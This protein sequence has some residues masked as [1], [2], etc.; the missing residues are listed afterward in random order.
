[1]A[2]TNFKQWNPPASNQESDTA[3]ATDAQ[4]TGGAAINSPFASALANKLFYQLTTWL[5]AFANSLVGKGFSPN[6]GSGNPSTAIAT[7]QSILANILTTA[8]TISY[9]QLS[10]IPASKIVPFVPQVVAVYDV[11]ALIGAVPPVSTLYVPPANGI[12]RVSWAALV[13]L[14]GGVGSTL[15][16]LTIWYT[17]NV[18]DV[19][20]GVVA[21]AQTNA[22]GITTSN[23]GNTNTSGLWGIPVL[24]NCRAGAGI[25]FSTAYSSPG[26][27]DEMRYSLHI[28]VEYMGPTA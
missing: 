5:E 22:G 20:I 18:E 2:S 17:D 8:D 13:T 14:P 11:D 24:L 10:N 7:L 19:P 9:T 21:A 27:G 12:Y 26:S 1:M 25:G 28:K 4:R 15:G 6:D 23:S 3:Y 16:P